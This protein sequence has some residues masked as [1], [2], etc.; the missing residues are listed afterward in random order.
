MIS[1]GFGAV[2]V[3]KFHAHL[4]A[5]IQASVVGMIVAVDTSVIAQPE[6]HLLFAEIH[7]NGAGNGR[8]EIRAQH[9]SVAVAVEE[10]IE[11]AG[12][13]RTDFLCKDVEEFKPRGLD[14]LISVG[15]IELLDLS[16]QIPL[17]VAFTAE[18]VTDTL[19]GVD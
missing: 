2:I 3:H 10:F 18:Y 6:R 8:R 12:G 19:G 13:S 15:M 14:R 7:G 16:L 11:I 17:P 9:Q 4:R 1:A 5:L